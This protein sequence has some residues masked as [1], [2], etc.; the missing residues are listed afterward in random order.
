[1]LEARGRHDEGAA[2]RLGAIGKLEAKG[3]VAAVARLGL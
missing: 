3:F 1:V 2:A